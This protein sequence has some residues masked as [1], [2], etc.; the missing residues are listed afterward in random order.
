MGGKV[1][2]SPN[3]TSVFRDAQTDTRS[4][5]DKRWP[6]YVQTP[7]FRHRAALGLMRN[8]ESVL[9][10]GSGDGL[11][12]SMVQQKFPN[13]RIEGADISAEAIKRCQA[14]G[15]PAQLVATAEA[16]PY[17]DKSFDTVVLLD[18]LEHTYEPDLILKE[19]ARVARKQII[20]GVPNFSSLPARMQ[21][22]AGKIPENNN[23]KKGHIY[24]FNKKTVAQVVSMSGCRVR[25]WSMN[26]QRPFRFVAGVLLSVWPNLFALSFVVDIEPR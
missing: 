10:I 14:R 20:V 26:V 3:I 23:P 16:L 12:L 5:E 24:W 21:T 8:P 2:E 18:V 13:A 25:V 11:L 9:D 15:I 19:A 6:T 1:V 4:F 7:E 17:A 22:L